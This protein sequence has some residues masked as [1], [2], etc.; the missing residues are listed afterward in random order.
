MAREL[1]GHR[2]VF[3]YP[4]L[5]S[6]WGTVGAA[7]AGSSS[8]GSPAGQ[9][10]VHV[11]VAALR[12]DVLPAAEQALAVVAGPLR[13]PPGSLVP[14]FDVQLKPVDAVQGQAPPGDRVQGRGGVAAA[15]VR[16]GD[17]VADAGPAEVRVPQPETRLADGGAAG[18]L[19]DGSE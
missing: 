3:A 1:A 16:G 10:A 13:G 7:A 5:M 19:G 4:M 9:Q 14:R 11:H 8:G 18:R 15:A 17:P 12:A 2:A 6:A